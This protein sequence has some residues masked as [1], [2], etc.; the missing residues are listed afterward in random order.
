MEERDKGKGKGT[1]EH[2]TMTKGLQQQNPQRATGFRSYVNVVATGSKHLTKRWT[3]KYVQASN[4]TAHSSIQLTI[5]MDKT[6]LTK[7]W[8][9]RL[10]NLMA[11]DR[12]EEELMW[13]EGEEIKPKYIGGNMV[14]LIG[15]A[16]IRTEELCREGV[17][18][19]LSMFHTLEKWSPSLRLG[20]RLV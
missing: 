8:V 18:S 17:E 16:D 12:L 1:A 2:M 10:R 6:W 19:G 9:G 15:L 20:F 14:L 3:P 13:D 5:S 7:A 4:M 11:F